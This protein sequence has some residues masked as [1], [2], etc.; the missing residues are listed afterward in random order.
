MELLTN[1][2]TRE[3]TPPATSMAVDGNTS[4]VDRPHSV[5]ELS[6]LLRAANVDVSAWGSGKAKSV[7]LLLEELRHGDSTL[8]RTSEGALLRVVEYVKVE[9]MLRGRVLVETHQDMNGS[10]RERFILLSEKMKPREEW[11]P[12]VVRGIFEELE[13]DEATF[14]IDEASASAETVTKSAVSYP[15]VMDFGRYGTDAWN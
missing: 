12:A 11:R 6:A 10:L 8:L 9:L 3:K 7:A 14:T 13:L 15:D 2:L 4:L 5:D 1:H